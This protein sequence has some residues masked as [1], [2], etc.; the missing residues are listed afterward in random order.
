MTSAA[1]LHF[2]HAALAARDVAAAVAGAEEWQQNGQDD[3]AAP[4]TSVFLLQELRKFKGVVPD[5]LLG[6]Y[7]TG[8]NAEWQPVEHIGQG[9]EMD[10]VSL[11]FHTFSSP[12]TCSVLSFYGWSRMF[13]TIHILLPC[14]VYPVY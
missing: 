14:L 13:L 3:C 12:A 10:R 11:L 2:L 9:E 7:K 4:W 5:V 8:M 6:Y 1:P